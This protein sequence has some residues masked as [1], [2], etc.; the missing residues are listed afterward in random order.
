MRK[1]I[2]KDMF[3][4]AALMLVISALGTFYV[5]YRQMS[6]QIETQMAHEGLCIGNAVEMF[7]NEE[8]INRY[9]AKFDTRMPLRLTIIHANGRVIYDNAADIRD[10]GG[11][12][13]HSERPEVIAAI[14]NGS[15]HASRVS[16][17]L[18]QRNYYYAL[19]ISN[20]NIIRIAYQ[21]NSIVFMILSIVPL[22]VICLV[23]CLVIGF[24]MADRMTK[25]IIK[26]IN[27]IDLQHPGKKFVYAELRPLLLRINRQNDERNR[28]EKLRQEF[29]ANVSH[30]LKTPLTSISGYA[31]LL[32]DG[33]VAAEDVP[34]FAEKIFKEA[35]RMINLVNDIIKISKL[36]EHRIGI[37]K[38]DVDL[39]KTAMDVSERLEMIAR[40]QKVS[41]QVEGSSSHV[42]AVAQMID[43][44]IYNL[45][46]NAVKYNRPGGSV[47][48]HIA[49]ENDK[50]KIEVTDT[51]I[52]IPEKYQDRVFE[53]FF[54]VDKSHSRQ[55]GGTGL[56]LAIVKHIV[57]Y[58]GGQ[59][60]LSSKTGEGTKVVVIL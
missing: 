24:L 31:E 44:L 51:G 49:M 28:N 5:Y 33:L 2:F 22:I 11:M 7:E 56:G 52:G 41:V 53:R 3:L 32:K 50:G 42:T 46:E 9:M 59:I 36:D 12:D 58:H 37:E 47:S 45:M 18:G 20:G 14:K 35:G 6:R 30:E 15:G 19:K 54:R 1:R 43:E 27:N 23:I 39:L 34:S 57:E 16:D 25:N 17:T 40:K 29:S 55:T 8:D 26:P 10:V 38:E 4:L 60:R 13:N 48:V 21:A